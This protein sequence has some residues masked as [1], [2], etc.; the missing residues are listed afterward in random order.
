M[1]IHDAFP[2]DM[3]RRLDLYPPALDGRT[4]EGSRTGSVLPADPPGDAAVVGMRPAAAAP[5]V[6]P[7]LAGEVEV[8][9]QLA[10]AVRSAALPPSPHPGG[11][12]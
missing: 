12:P 8:V 11:S 6:P 9:A 7:T 4:I 2:H 10:V 3:S 1:E 5:S